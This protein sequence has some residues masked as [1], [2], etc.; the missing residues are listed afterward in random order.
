MSPALAAVMALF[1]LLDKMGEDDPRHAATYRAL[2]NSIGDLNVADQVA[3]YHLVAEDDEER[4]TY[5]GVA[6]EA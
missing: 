6:G 1:D 2:L 3:L 4:P 5:L